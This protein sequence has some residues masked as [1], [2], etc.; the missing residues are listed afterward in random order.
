MGSR[1]T[2]IIILREES[3]TNTIVQYEICKAQITQAE[4]SLGN[5]TQ[6]GGKS[7]Q[8]VLFQS[9]GLDAFS[10]SDYMFLRW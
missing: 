5:C 9:C 8:R 2:D 4:E 7:H 6:Q 1:K 3:A 10:F